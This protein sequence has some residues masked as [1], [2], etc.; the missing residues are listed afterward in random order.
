V[1]TD[2]CRAAAVIPVRRTRLGDHAFVDHAGDDARGDVLSAFTGFGPASGERAMVFAALGV[3]E[4]GVRA[5]LGPAGT[6]RHPLPGIPPV[7]GARAEGG[8]GSGAD[9]ERGERLM[10]EEVRDPSADDPADETCRLERDFAEG[11]LPTLRVL[12]EEFALR[13]GLPA[14]RR[15]EFVLAVNEVASNAI[16]HGGGRGRL[17]LRRTGAEV[18]CRVS[19]AGPGFSASVIPELLPGLH[20]RRRRGL[21]LARLVTDRL[22]VDAGVVGAV[23]TLAIRL[24]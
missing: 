20:S 3:P 7:T 9:A 11:D 14:S 2:A 5:R 23:V 19:D 13:A 22:T 15:G 10:L 1:R 16:V 18:Q 12:T 8:V 21:W 24:G 4:R 17:T 6:P